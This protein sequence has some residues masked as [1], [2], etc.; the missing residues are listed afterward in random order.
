LELIAVTV[1]SAPSRSQLIEVARRSILSEG[2]KFSLTSIT[3]ELNCSRSYIRRFFP[4]KANL[5]SAVFSGNSEDSVDRPTDGGTGESTRSK[6]LDSS[7]DW[8]MRRF[9]V[10][11]R[12]IMTLESEI[13]A[14]RKDY[15]RSTAALE[16]R[17]ANKPPDECISEPL[18]SAPFI[19]S[20]GVAR[21][22]H[23]SNK[24]LAG[25]YLVASEVPD[26]RVE[27][28]FREDLPPVREVPPIDYGQGE[29]QRYPFSGS[30]PIQNLES[31]D[32]NFVSAPPNDSMRQDGWKEI[33]VF[34][35]SAFS[36]ALLLAVIVI[37]F[38][39]VAGASYLPRSEIKNTPERQTKSMNRKRSQFATGGSASDSNFVINATGSVLPASRPTTLVAKNLSLDNFAIESVTLNEAAGI[40]P[41]TKVK[42]ALAY[43]RGDGVK[44]DPMM[45]AFWSGAAAQQGNADA[46]YI[47]GTL[48]SEGIKPD[49]VQ[50]FRWLSSAA[51][52]G[53]PKAMHNLAIAFLNGVGV[54]K[55][56]ASAVNWFVRAA[57]LGYRDSAFDLGT[58]YERG[59]GVAQNS[60][61]ALSWYDNAASLGDREAARRAALLRSDGLQ[62][63]D[64][65]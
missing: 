59:E 34:G 55:D 3:K 22:P 53:N 48:Y 41:E 27:S 62:S 24:H 23:L 54:A 40:N 37:I 29:D 14:L 4:S 32:P 64:R 33:V 13:E 15:A 17:F 65:N 63:S 16:R 20:T 1:T 10:F 21:K 52:R 60:H 31:K 6:N 11:E 50:A 47:L 49:A 61:T 8:V 51:V 58:L 18:S 57:N 42:F 2:S 56:K 36:A 30:P 9:R 26:T 5:I 28:N 39:S 43:L 46:Q 44:A 35:L 19:N 38:T 25:A 12:A 45:G 7:D